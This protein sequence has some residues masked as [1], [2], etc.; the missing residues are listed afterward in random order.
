M[1]ELSITSPAVV[2]IVYALAE[3]IKKILLK[4]D[5]QRAILPAICI[6][7]GIV[8]SV[9]LFSIW[10]DAMLEKTIPDAIITGGMS[11]MAA[12]GVN[13]IKL[14][15]KKFKDSTDNVDNNKY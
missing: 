10:P 14:Q 6:L 5:E 11:G 12:T 2:I 1:E 7:L 3:I 8:I 15:Y 9:A 13:Q 4:T